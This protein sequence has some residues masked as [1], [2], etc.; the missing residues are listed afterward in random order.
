MT[1]RVPDPPDPEPPEPPEDD[2]EHPA[3]TLTAI[4]ATMLSIPRPS[5]K[6]LLPGMSYSSRRDCH[7]M[8]FI[9]AQLHTVVNG[10]HQV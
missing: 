5:R 10:I 6:R 2:K 8:V 1:V 7:S 4:T 9:E 3:D